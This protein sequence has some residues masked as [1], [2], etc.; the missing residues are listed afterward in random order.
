MF[1]Q[2]L[3]L[4][5]T[6]KPLQDSI[7]MS[8]RAESHSSCPAAEGGTS[9]VFLQP[10]TCQ[11]LGMGC[12]GMQAE[13]PQFAA[14]SHSHLRTRNQRASWGPQ[15]QLLGVF[16]LLPGSPIALTGTDVAGS[17]GWAWQILG[18]LPGAAVRAGLFVWALPAA[19]HWFPALLI[20]L[21]G[22]FGS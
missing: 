20:P 6:P 5:E 14:S 10:G 11:S 15:Q 18:M 2:C 4:F 7:H 19:P 3:T 17:V 16:F 12:F 9:R 22:L 13:T 8:H 21:W 1:S